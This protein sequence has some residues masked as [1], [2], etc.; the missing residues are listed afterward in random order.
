VDGCRNIANKNGGDSS[1]N[2]IAG[3]TSITMA[4]W[5]RGRD[6]RI[7]LYANYAYNNYA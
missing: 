5:G 1:R 6:G 2:E 4:H 7:I 3:N